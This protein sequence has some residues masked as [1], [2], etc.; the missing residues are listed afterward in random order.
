M[1]SSLLV[2]QSPYP[3]LEISIS[4]LRWYDQHARSLPWR[5]RPGSSIVSPYHVWL[6]EIMLQQTTVATVGPYFEKF[7]NLWPQIE[8]LAQAPLEDI[9]RAWAGLGYYTRARNLHACA[10]KIMTHHQGVFPETEEA[11]LHLP[12]IG[13]YTAAA[14]RAIAFQKRAIVIDG[15]IERVVS[16]LFAIDTPLP[17]A[18]K[19]I[20]RAT[21]EIT[22]RERIG[23][24]VQSLMDLG[25]SICTPRNP[26]CSLCPLN[27]YCK[28][29]QQL[30]PTHFPVKPPKAKRPLRFGLCF[31]IRRDDGY[32][33][34]HRRPLKGLLGGMV[35]L[36][37]TEWLDHPPSAE[38]ALS[39]L[40]HF[41]NLPPHLPLIPIAG[42][43]KHVFT[44][45]ELFLSFSI[46]HVPAPTPTICNHQWIEEELLDKEALP[47]V[48]KKSVKHIRNSY[49]FS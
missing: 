5:A 2:V 1:N 3:S 29:Y 26:L 23:D 22:P 21:D 43:V 11:L 32:I 20:H 41:L 7:I 37:G 9:L 40:H 18:K 39:Y 48:M 10:Q 35:G 44:H 19:E 42:H 6:S 45:F 30:I 28:A 31:Y 17:Q 47:S 27:T 13:P 49:A 12:G 46:L 25:A 34:T 16:R 36:P 15:N 33:L 8:D 14:I 24:F 38:M 4:M